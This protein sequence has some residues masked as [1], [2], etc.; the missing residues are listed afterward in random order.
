MRLLDGIHHIAFITSDMDRL[1]SFYERIFEARVTLDLEEEGLRHVFIEVGP[2]T[3][4]HPFEVPGIEAPG[5]QPLFHRGR[6]DH[7]AFHASSEEVFREL[8]RRLVAEGVADGTVTDMGSLLTVSF[9]D[10][11]EGWHEV[12]WAKPGVSSGATTKLVDWGTV[13]MD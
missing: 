11:D 8:R 4:L 1:I 7:F 9:T 6:I 12:V 5:E 2:N 10:P 3:L 13:E